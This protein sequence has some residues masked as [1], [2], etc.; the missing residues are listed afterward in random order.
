MSGI[1]GISLAAV[2]LTLVLSMASTAIRLDMTPG[3]WQAVNDGVM[4]GVSSGRIV[5][6]EQGL[7]F[8]GPARVFVNGRRVISLDR[9]GGRREVEVDF[10]SGTN[11]VVVKLVQDE[12]SPARF[13][14]RA[15]D[16]DGLP[17]RGLGNELEE[18]YSVVFVGER[19]MQ[20]LVI[21]GDYKLSNFVSLLPF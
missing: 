12:R 19:R 21:I 15:R 7:R 9:W 2:C 3:P 8:E 6:A 14:M 11:Y 5:A 16:I 20:E 17:L 4:G 13:R 1:P 18:S 10:G